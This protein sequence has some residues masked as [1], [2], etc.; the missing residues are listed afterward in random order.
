MTHQEGTAPINLMDPTPSH[1]AGTDRPMWLDWDMTPPLALYSAMKRRRRVR[2]AQ[3][4]AATA[5]SCA[6]ARVVVA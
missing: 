4:T 3:R 6:T 5:V 1:Q 2:I